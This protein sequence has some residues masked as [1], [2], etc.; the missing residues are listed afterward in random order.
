[1]GMA[2]KHINSSV[3][4]CFLALLIRNLLRLQLHVNTLASLVM[5][6]AILVH[7]Y[8]HPFGPYIGSSLS[9]KLP[10]QGQMEKSIR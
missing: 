3:N 1:M 10:S 6:G 5:C 4:C 2:C 8:H 7:L 9:Q